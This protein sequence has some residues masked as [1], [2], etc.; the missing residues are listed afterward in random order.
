M[1]ADPLVRQGLVEAVHLQ[2]GAAGQVKAQVQAV[3]GGG[4][5]MILAPVHPVHAVVDVANGTALQP[6]QQ[7]PDQGHVA[8]VEGH[9]VD[10]AGVAGR[11]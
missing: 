3:H 11:L 6:V 2:T 10:R 7:G 1:H 9:L 5:K 8:A 4:V